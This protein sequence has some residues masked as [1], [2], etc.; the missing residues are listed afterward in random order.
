MYE[1]VGVFK[2]A[3]H[4]RVFAPRR[5]LLSYVPERGV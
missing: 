2:E 3:G 5:R 1:T 4:L